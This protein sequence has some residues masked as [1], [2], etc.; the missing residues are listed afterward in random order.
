MGCKGKIF[1]FH[2]QI[3]FLINKDV[4]YNKLD[5]V[6]KFHT[7][8]LTLLICKDFLHLFLFYYF[9]IASD[10]HFEHLAC[11]TLTLQR[12]LKKQRYCRK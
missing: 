7:C 9:C 3:F 4:Y 5:F 8:F 11:L 6:S 2:T 10:V 12:I 1:L